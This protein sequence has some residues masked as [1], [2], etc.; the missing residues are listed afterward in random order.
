MRSLLLGL[1]LAVALASMSSTARAA[2]VLGAEA[3]GP[4]KAWY[5]KLKGLEVRGARIERG[6]VI[7]PLEGGCELVLSH[8]SAPACATHAPFG[9]ALLCW[10][11]EGCPSEAKRAK[12]LE[13]AGPLSLPWRAAGGSGGAGTGGKVRAELLALRAEASDRLLISDHAGAKAAMAKA[14]AFG[15]V[16]PIEWLSVLPIASRAGHGVPAWAKLDGGALAELP[17]ATRAA[18]HVTLLM[19]AAAGASAGEALLE[20]RTACGMMPL[21]DAYLGIQEPRAAGRLAAAARA[22]DERCFAAYATEAEAWTLLRDYER[23]RIVSELALERFAEHPDIARIEEPYLLAHGRGSVVLE[24][25]EARLA[26]GDKT[27]GLL[28]ELLS[29]YIVVKGR[30]ARLAR[31]EA[32]V[33]ADP[34]D[35]V[36]RFF[37]GVLHHYE[38]DYARSQE[39]LRPV[40]EH[41]PREPRLYIYLAMN[42]FNLGDRPSAER[43]ITEAARL[44]LRDPDVPYCTAEVFRDSDR[45]RALAAVEQYLHMTKDTADPRS[46]KQKRVFAMRDALARC[47]VEAPPGPCMGP[48][49]HTFDSVR[50]RKER[51][52]GGR[53]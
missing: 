1:L 40:M 5:P 27:P 24:R 45:P 11:G 39:Y 25:L 9:E 53:R 2:P 16:R 44:E 32:K 20:G 30:V 26:R 21:A 22:K 36:A 33:Q 46:I 19:G 41:F 10:R 18:L 43:W 29:F 37:A 13:A 4:V 14:L 8:P 17:L 38:K 42:A 52:A 34:R 51:E 31:F 6:D 47:A 23:Q 7:V 48:F 50:I 35:M 28:K 3:A 49:E 15:G 12:A